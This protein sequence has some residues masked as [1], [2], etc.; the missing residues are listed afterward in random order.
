MGRR[1]SPETKCRIDGCDN[2][3]RKHKSLCG[4]HNSRIYRYGSPDTP[5]HKVW[6]HI[7]SEVDSESMVAVCAECG[8]TKIKI[9]SNRW[10]C[11]NSEYMAKLRR[12]AAIYGLT[13]TEFDA[14]MARASYRC[15]ICGSKN[16]LAID[17]DHA[18][19]KVR[20][21]LCFSCNTGIGSLG[22]TMDSLKRALSY[23]EERS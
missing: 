10:V 19:N 20:G 21:I 5:K 11:S 9:K 13:I 1:P 22:D 12:R 14:L 3:R 4:V 16:R 18:T 23:L 7:L 17:H 8:I 2:D 6:K 15:E